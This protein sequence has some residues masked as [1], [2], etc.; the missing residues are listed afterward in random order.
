[1][2]FKA[3]SLEPP[4]LARTASWM[5]NGVSSFGNLRKVLFPN[6]AQ[7]TCCRSPQPWKSVY[8][9]P[10]KECVVGLAVGGVMPSSM[11]GL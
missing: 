9:A 11:S 6:L 2:S 5:C 4:Q 3:V 8:S 10:V 1:M 7:S